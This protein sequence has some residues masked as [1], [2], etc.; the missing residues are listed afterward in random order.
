MSASTSTKPYLLRA[1]Y[2]WCVDNGFTPYLSVTVSADTRVPMEYVHD[3]E[4][5]LNIGPLASNRLQI[6][7]ESVEFAA[8]FGGVAR[9]ISIPMA[10]VTQ[11]FAHET[12]QGMV[13]PP[14][15]GKSGDASEPSHAGEDE[16]RTD[17]PKP[18]G[19]PVLRRVK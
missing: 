19:R 1:L 8:R 10:A 16:P 11:I 3:G 4:I 18:S 7:Q 13:F 9:D 2:E 12:G 14:E 6:G 17:P 5:V 15:S